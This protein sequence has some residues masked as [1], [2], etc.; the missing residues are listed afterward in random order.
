MTRRWPAACLILS[1]LCVGLPPAAGQCVYDIST[2]YDQVQGAVLPEGSPDDEYSVDDGTNVLIPVTGGASTGFPVPTWI[3]NDDASLWISPASDANALPG[4][5]TYE[6]SFRIPAGAEASRLTLIGRWATDDPGLDVLVNGISTGITAGG[7]LA[8]TDFPI[9]AGLGLLETGD[10]TIAFVVENGGTAANPTGLRV[11][12]C[13]GLPTPEE[14][15]FDISTGFLQGSLTLLADGAADD[16]YTIEGPAGSGVAGAATAVADDGFPI[17]P[18]IA[19]GVGSRWVGT[20]KTDSEGPAGEYIY[21]IQVTLPGDFP[22]DRA[23]L[24]GEFAAD[25]RVAE[26]LVN[27][28]ETG[29]SGEW[30]DVFTPFPVDAGMGL[31]APGTNTIEFIVVNDEE[32]PTGLRV[33]GEIALG[34]EPCDARTALFSLDTG[35]DDEA[36]VTIANDTP[37][38]NYVVLGPPGSD[39]GPICAHVLPDTAYPIEPA[40]PW[41]GSSAQSKWIGLA[42][43]SSAGP[44][45]I[46]IFRI[47]VDLADDIPADLVRLVGMWTS[48]N[49]GIDIAI[50]GVSTGARNDGNLGAMS[51]FLGDVGFGLFRNGENVIEFFVENAAPG[52]NPVGLR[53]EAVVGTGTFDP[54]D[55]ATGLGLRGIGLLP[56]GEDDARYIVSGPPDSGIDPRPATVVGSLA[57]GWAPNTESSRWIGLDGGNSE[58]PAGTYTYEITFPLGAQ[59]LPDRVVLDGTLGGAGRISDVILND[60]SLGISASGSAPLS[61]F[62]HDSGRGLFRTGDNVLRIQVENAASG[63]TGIRIEAMVR[64]ITEANPLDISTGFDQ[65][66]GSP[67]DGGLFDDDYELTEPSLA[68]DLAYVVPAGFVHSSWIPNTEASHWIGP[69]SANATVPGLYIYAT[70]VSLTAEQAAMARIEGGWAVDDDGVDIVINGVSTGVQNTSGFA[71]LAVFPPDCGK[72]LFAEGENW[73]EFHVQN[74]GQDPNPSGLRVDARIAV[75]EPSGQRFIR[76]DTNADGSKDLGDAIFGLNYQFASGRT[77]VC[78]KTADTNDDGQIDLGDPIFWLNYIFADGPSPPPPI[79]ECGADPTQDPLSCEEFPP[80]AGGR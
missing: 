63:P 41:L 66:I 78:L 23:V 2:G 61:S 64:E 58:G 68:I 50:N 77:P 27:G 46:Y 79:A 69:V 52:T 19:N 26:I 10:N 33:D 11:E 71:V 35:F 13:V 45:G 30:P 42:T 76:G 29:V 57:A 20:S 7:F 6:I 12:A 34:P 67:I 36:G 72:G 53:V 73:I 28:M 43:P 44:P 80:C 16:D 49:T 1:L 18:W 65:G 8:W 56:A 25:E 24:R 14:R 5:Y 54:R 40:G 47:R 60:V 70:S 48:D 22:A 3:A 62:P 21:R 4:I 9:D 59:F 15:P 32:G 38:D 74:G 51:P 75:S 17:P 31:F 37:D 55:L 39:L